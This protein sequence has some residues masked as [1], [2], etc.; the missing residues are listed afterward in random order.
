MATPFLDPFCGA[1]TFPLNARQRSPVQPVTQ[2][3]A[4][5]LEII[6]GDSEQVKSEWRAMLRDEVGVRRHGASRRHRMYAP[7]IDLAVGPFATHRQFIWE[8][9]ELIDHSAGMIEAMLCCYRGNLRRF[10]SVFAAPPFGQL[11]TLNQNARCFLAIEIEK[12]NQS[13]KY[14][15]GSSINASALGRIGIVLAWDQCRLG[16]LLRG[17]EFL[18]YMKQLDKN[19]F[20]TNNLLFLSKEQ[21]IRVLER[22]AGGYYRRTR[23]RW[24]TNVERPAT[25]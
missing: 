19:S 13:L 9:D 10:E 23:R 24:C 20:D 2:Q 4:A 11:C 3:I 12:G 17:R 15:I 8:Y 14:L 22:R 16:D 7:A 5:L 25:K 21:F 1:G 6:Y 18:S